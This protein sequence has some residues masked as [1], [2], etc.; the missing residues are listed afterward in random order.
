[1]LRV[2]SGMQDEMMDVPGTSRSVLD[3]VDEYLHEDS[4]R[5]EGGRSQQ[6]TG[7]SAHW[8][9]EAM[10]DLDQLSH[11]LFRDKNEGKSEE[12]SLVRPDMVFSPTS[13]PLVMPT[14]STSVGTYDTPFMLPQPTTTTPFLNASMTSNSSTSLSSLRTGKK[15][16][17]QGGTSQ[18]SPL[19][20]PALAAI[21]QAQAVNFALPESTVSTLVKKGAG[22]RSKKKAYS[23]S[24]ATNAKISKCS[25]RMKP[26]AASSGSSNSS[27]RQYT[28]E[29]FKNGSPVIAGESSGWDD[30]IFRLPES[31]MSDRA[32]GR[33]HNDEPAP[34]SSTSSP[35]SRMTPVA[36]MNY[37]KVILPSTSSTSPKDLGADGEKVLR[38]TESPV[39]K[40][41]MLQHHHHHQES[42]KPSLRPSFSPK[43]SE[44]QETEARPAA[45]KNVSSSSLPGGNGSSDDGELSKKEVHKVAEQGRRNRLNMALTDLSSLLP[46][47]LKDSIPIP[48]KATTVELACTYIR[49][50]LATKNA[51]N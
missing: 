22:A 50:L 35:E 17:K 40:P 27:R 46:P 7:S 4:H 31:S 42:R 20:S 49:Q 51:S 16:G 13:S 21:D 15:A 48:S 30:V 5:D 2:E 39:I 1:M 9:P 34:K 24:A 10:E 47:E 33:W 6:F 11:S 26:A 18:F 25:P 3:Q 43:I 37:P 44:I 8:E 29:Q 45:Q 23:S 28:A 36:L 41:K 38:A 12:T 14:R 32:S 19:S